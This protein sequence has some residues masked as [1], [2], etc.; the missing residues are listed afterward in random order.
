MVFP[1]AGRRPRDSGARLDGLL[2]LLL[3]PFVGSFLGV[4]IRRLPLG[5]PVAVGRSECESCGRALLPR[6]MVPL[7]SYFL[8]RGRCRFCRAGI[9]RFHLWVELAA[10]VVAAG[11]LLARPGAEAGAAWADC[12][13]GWWLLALAWID[14]DHLRLPD[15]L[16]LPLVMAGLLVTWV[17][18]PEGVADH[19]VA[20][21]VAYLAFRGIAWGYRALRGREGLGQGDAKLLAASGA[22]VGVAG[23]PNVV[24]GAAVA[25]LVV[26]LGGRVF[27]R[28]A[29]GDV[30]VPFGP[31]LAL[32]TWG[33]R[34][35]GGVIA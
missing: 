11:A 5:R 31:Y 26:T 27:G 22:W 2:P 21:V 7:L 20:A 25:A 3:S 33:V 19:A 16:T 13:L 30:P 4:V 8:L 1:R 17:Q 23:L 14:W 10:V 18:E 6:D 9:A 28:Q 29:G 12:V 35:W 34:V 24:L 32:A 15:V